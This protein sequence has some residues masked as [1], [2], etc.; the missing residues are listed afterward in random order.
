MRYE[1]FDPGDEELIEA[2]ELPLEGGIAVALR[3][4]GYDTD[5]DEVLQLAIVDFGGSE[6][7]SKTV[8]PQNKEKWEPSEASGGLAPA[9]VEDA[10]EL[11]QFEEEVSDLFE[12]ASLV[13]GQHMP[14]VQD[15]IESSWVTLP[16]F[17]PFDLVERFCASHCTTDY[18]NEPAAIATLEGIARYY[19][20]DADESTALGTARAIAACYRALVGEH[21][22]QRA[23]KGE[24]YWERREQRLAAEA[25]ANASVN[26][27]ARLR[28]KRF[29]Q[30]NGLLWVAG[31]IIFVSLIIQLYQRGGDVSFMVVCG[32]FA[33]FCFIRAVANFRK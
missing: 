14:F 33:V 18:R 1:F 11:F 25:A 22:E 23:A 30:M 29:N 17:Q 21:A 5:E 26:A 7:F 27:A 20:I 9:D 3:S 31:G 24:A 16:A 32:A 8:K 13:V 10:P 19:G 12:N 4:T 15:V 6:L 2:S 28:E